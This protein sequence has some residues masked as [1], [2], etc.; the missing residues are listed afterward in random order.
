[1]RSLEARMLTETWKQREEKGMRK[2]MMWVLAFAVLL[3]GIAS[4]KDAGAGRNAI[5]VASTSV[6]VP[7]VAN[8]TGLTGS[9]FRSRI[10]LFNPTAFT[11]PIRATFH[12][13][14]GNISNVNI[15]MA[16]SQMRVYDNF[17]GDVFSTTG[18]G[19]VRFESRLITGGSPNFQFVVNAEVWTV[20]SS[21]RYGTSVTTLTGTASTSDAY[22]AGIRVDSDFRSNVGCFNDSGNTN[23]VVADVFDG[24]NNLVTTVTLSVP[25][26]AWAQAAIPASLAA[27]YVRF[28]PSQPAYCFAVVVNNTT[29]DG[30][31]ILASEFTP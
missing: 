26:N 29:N 2:I 27:G 25:P 30:H 13:I 19:S 15:T 1:M 24:S 18:A 17:L 4:G 9:V 28:R 23:I 12:D 31:F 10:S 8:V 16:A 6:V 14:A 11:Y 20:V 21:G 5:E 7:S 3:P 22:S